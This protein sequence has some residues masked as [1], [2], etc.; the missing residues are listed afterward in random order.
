MFVYV[1][2][3]KKCSVYYNMKILTLNVKW[4]IFYPL[5][6]KSI[7]NVSNV[8]SKYDYDFIALQE[9]DLYI[10]ETLKSC[11]PDSFVQRYNVSYNLQM[12]KEHKKTGIILLYRTFNE[13]KKEYHGDL[14]TELN[15]R[16]NVNPRPYS[17]YRF[18]NHTFLIHVHM[19]HNHEI[20][21]IHKH[22]DRLTRFAAF[23]PLVGNFLRTQILRHCPPHKKDHLIFCGDMNRNIVQIPTFWDHL[24]L[25]KPFVLYNE[26]KFRLATYKKD[27]FD[28]II[29]TLPRSSVIQYE[30]LGSEYTSTFSD[31]LGVFLH[32]KNPIIRV[33]KRRHWRSIQRVSITKY[34]HVISNH[35]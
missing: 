13:I 4:N 21:E 2:Q 9:I 8:I 14:I 25:H 5:R 31:H 34:S 24:T 18:S 35:K 16:Q 7:Q 11:L 19:P 12:N 32:L 6:L 26:T 30:T 17:L 23:G 10:W 3:R 28:H 33:T 29:T 20:D 27:H 22:K 15:H 1:Y